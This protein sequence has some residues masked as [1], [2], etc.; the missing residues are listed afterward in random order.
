[1]KNSC[2]RVFGAA[3]L[4]GRKGGLVLALA[5]AISALSVP[6]RAD[7]VNGSINESGIATITAG[8]LTFCNS[9]T[10]L[11][12]Q[13]PGT[14][15]TTSWV[16]PSSATGSFC[17]TASANCDGPTGTFDYQTDSVSMTD[18]N[19]V[20]APVGTVL[21]GHGIPFIVFN[22]TAGLPA[23]P[24]EL[25]ISE[26]FA[27]TGT[28]ANCA[29]GTGPCTPAGANS[30]TLTNQPGGNA[31]AIIVAAG[32]AESET[33]QF[34]PMQIIFTAQFN[35]T[36]QQLLTQFNNTGFITTSYSGSF[37]A[38][39]VPEPSTIAMTL[40]GGALVLIGRRRNQ[41]RS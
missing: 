27:G 40:L 17:A 28:A 12:G 32:Y 13:C 1:M 35:E 20:N 39:A 8:A 15:G 10:E 7:F 26:L 21:P 25:F 23:T 37:T 14:A 9:G 3:G 5:F 6:A 2:I 29:G 36:V 18:L 19:S 33:G 31:S 11:N 16:V 22:P 4:S 41:S 38:T 30:V 34:D 24:I